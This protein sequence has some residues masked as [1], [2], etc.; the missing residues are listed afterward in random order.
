MNAHANL[1]WTRRKQG[2][3]VN[4][5]KIYEH[6]YLAALSWVWDEQENLRMRE[7]AEILKRLNGAYTERRLPEGGDL[8]PSSPIETPF[9]TEFSS[10]VSPA[11]RVGAHD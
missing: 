5:I 11:T 7:A 2:R 10:M 1:A 9:V 6:Q 8:P 4:I 3:C